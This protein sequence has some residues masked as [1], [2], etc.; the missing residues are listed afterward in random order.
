MANATSTIAERLKKEL[1]DLPENFIVLLIVPAEK[2]AEANSELLKYMVTEKNLQGIYITINKPYKSILEQLKKDK[3]D[4][5]KIFF[6]DAITQTAGGTPEKTDEVLYMASPQNLTDMGIAL[7]QALQSI[8]AKEK[9]LFL[10]SLNTLLIY[11]SADTVASFTH[12]LTGKIRVMGLK[13]VFIS[14][15]KDTDHQLIEMLS[16]FGD[17]II[18][19]NGGKQL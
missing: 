14:L 16:Q 17:K 5:K 13:G 12:F 10:D 15:K 18:Y 6:I 7:E 11:N 9:F 3:I 19:L 2:Y 1:A 8:Q 4:P